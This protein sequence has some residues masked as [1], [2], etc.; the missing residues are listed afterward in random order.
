[1]TRRANAILGVLAL[2][3]VVAYAARNGL[4]TVYPDL[5]AR[6]GLQD[7]RLG[8]L[9]TAFL[10]PHAIA[11]LPFAW[12]GDRYDR[13]RVIAFGLAI[14]AVAS[15]AG[16]L[17]TTTAE[18]V[19]SR[20]FVGF[21]MAAVVPIANSI[22]G[23][24]FDSSIKASRMSLFNLGLLIGGVVGFGVGLG[25]GFPLVVVVLAIPPALLAFA[26][27]ALPVP[28]HPSPQRGL[29]LGRY[30]LEFGRLFVSEG[31]ALW[32][33]RTLRWVIA[34]TTAMAFATGG[35]NAWLIDYLER[36]KHMSK[37]A[38]TELLSIA[39]VGAIVGILAGGRIADRLSRRLVTGRLWTI[40][41]GMA[42]TAPCAAAAIALPADARLYVAGVAIMFFISWYH[43]PMAV[44]V[45]DLAPPAR[46]AA[47]QGLVIFAMHLVGTAPSSY[48]LGLV[49]RSASITA[50]MWVP[51]AA[52]VVAAGCMVVATRSFAADRQAAGRPSARMG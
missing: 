30:A 50:A 3:N 12:A 7:D 39:M 13:R 20:A 28:P 43:A 38:A 35:Y 17:A 52:L 36:A 40:A 4:F 37:A 21:G 16:A 34:S 5:R 8:L 51:T 14:A 33:I 32:R 1:M 47:A 22:I 42:C 44:T 49:S 25:V 24:L 48:V 23:Q 19:V 9:T 10:L 15:A 11:T 31:R 41:I 18:L 29:P 26:I 45:D 46:I 6:F 27:P 2:A